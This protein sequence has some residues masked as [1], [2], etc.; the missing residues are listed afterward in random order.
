MSSSL[1][2]AE[3][4]RGRGAEGQRGRGAEGQRGRGGVISELQA[5][6]VSMVFLGEPELHS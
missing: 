4:Q 1:W 5:S 2:E 3:G 6:L